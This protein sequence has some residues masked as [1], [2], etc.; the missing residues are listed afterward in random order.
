MNPSFIYSHSF[1]SIESRENKL[2][3][4][5]LKDP[6]YIESSLRIIK[7]YKEL[8][9]ICEKYM[10]EEDKRLSLYAHELAKYA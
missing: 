9:S 10:T 8:L 1:T 4:H 6:K 7:K 5:N 2:K 3:N